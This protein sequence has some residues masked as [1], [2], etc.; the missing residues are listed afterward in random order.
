MAIIE[1]HP[2]N[3]WELLLEM[4]HYHLGWPLSMNLTQNNL[5]SGLVA[6]TLS[7]PKVALPPGVTLPPGITSV[8]SIASILPTAILNPPI[9]LPGHL[10][11]GPDGTGPGRSPGGQ[12]GGGAGVVEVQDTITGSAADGWVRSYT[13]ISKSWETAR[14]TPDG[15]YSNNDDATSVDAMAA[16][17][18]GANWRIKRSFFYFDLSGLPAGATVTACIL[19]LWGKINHDNNVSA[20]EG[21]QGATL[22]TDDYN[23]F[24]GNEFGHVDWDADSSDTGVKNEI[25]FNDDGT[26]YISGVMGSEAKICCREYE[27]D[28][29]GDEP[30][31]LNLNGVLYRN[32]IYVASR[33]KLVITYQTGGGTSDPNNCRPT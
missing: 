19:Q 18:D 29:V 23:A 2:K 16:S 25:T 10:A 3:V 5:I 24:D 9:S 33:P 14:S 6:M 20:Q 28:Y 1:K 7:P 30:T 26:S 31:G 15:M 27:H 32:T 11:P 22:D 8:P 13:N 17:K 4:M 21:T 12:G